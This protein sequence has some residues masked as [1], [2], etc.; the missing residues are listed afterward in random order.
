M[1]AHRRS[2]AV[3]LIDWCAVLL[4][5][6]RAPWAA[7][8][9]AEVGAV[10]NSDAALSFAAGCV[11]GS[12]K[13]RTLTMNFAARSVR[14]ATIS[15]MAGLALA[16]G[17]LAGRMG[18]VH[19]PSAMIFGLTS[20]LF[21]AAAVW[22]YLRG[23]M[24]LVQAAS[25]TIPFYLIAYAFVSRDDGIPGVWAN[26]KLYQALAI[27]GI[28]IWAALLAGGI[29]MLRAGALPLAERA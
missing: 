3:M 27:E 21:A 9:K 26:A 14:F 5:T 25:S 7:A 16:S 19:A 15:A 22:S 2:L 23:P 6:D 8:M 28:V 1:S 11:W 20:A 12:I 10:E 29:F 13:E 18:E 4:P 17:A 24:A